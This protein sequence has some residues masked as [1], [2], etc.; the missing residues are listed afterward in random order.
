MGD[1]RIRQQ[2]APGNVVLYRMAFWKRKPLIEFQRR[3]V[4]HPGAAIERRDMT[5]KDGAAYGMCTANSHQ[6]QHERRARK[7]ANVRFHERSTAGK[8]QQP[9]FPAGTQ[10]RGDQPAAFRDRPPRRGSSFARR[11]AGHWDTHRAAL[12]SNRSTR[13]RPVTPSTRTAICWLR[14]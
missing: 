10:A 12:K 7:Q 6:V 8:I 2:A 11:S 1:V 13:T 5:T 4:P 14:P 9:D 3:P